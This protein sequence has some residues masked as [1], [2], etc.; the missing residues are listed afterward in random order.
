MSEG[1]GEWADKE[2]RGREELH[3]KMTRADRA[4]RGDMQGKVP[5]I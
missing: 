2:P 3:V 1:D 4:T 5:K